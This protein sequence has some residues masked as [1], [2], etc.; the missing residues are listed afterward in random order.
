MVG[1]AGTGVLLDPQG[2]VLATAPT[3][4]ASVL[5][6]KVSAPW[7]MEPGQRTTGPQ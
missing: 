7:A 5:G 4:G 1:A 3:A 2:L 6:E